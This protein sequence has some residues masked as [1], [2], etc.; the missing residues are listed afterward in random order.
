[1]RFCGL[2]GF[3]VVAL[4]AAGALAGCS[5]AS[6]PEGQPA[7][8]TVTSTDFAEGGQIPADFTCKGA[9]R[10]PSLAWSGDTKGAKAL[11]VIVDDP[12]APSGTY[13]HWIV[14]DLPASATTLSSNGVRGLKEAKNSGGKKGW[15]PPCPPSGTHH[16]RF[17]VYALQQPTGL[18]DGAERTDALDTIGRLAVGSGRITGTVQH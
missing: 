7:T 9:G 2:A 3:G 5:D 18:A 11:A 10:A 13:V 4:V 17:T 14:L 15:T 8:L 16:Y 1:V 6:T 12:D